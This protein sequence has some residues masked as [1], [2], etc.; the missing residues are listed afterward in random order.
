MDAA[1]NRHDWG[2]IEA[3]FDP[4]VEIVHPGIGSVRG[5]DDNLAVMRLIMGAID[6]YR[7]QRHETVCDGDRCAFRFTITGRHTGDLPGFP[8]TGEPVEIMGAIF[9]EARQGHLVRIV[10]I[11][12]HDSIRGISLR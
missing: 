7:R 3:V 12:E 1:E 9:A 11:L 4:D 10:E 2:A 5:R 6:G 8:A